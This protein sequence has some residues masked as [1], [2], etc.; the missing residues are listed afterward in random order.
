MFK[1]LSS[2][3]S[4]L[5][6]AA[7]ACLS[8]PSFAEEEQS[9][10]EKN[11]TDASDRTGT[12]PVNFARDIRVYNEY[13]WLNTEGDG[14]QNVTT[15]EYRQSLLDG[16]WQFRTKVP[17]VTSIEADLNDDG[18][19]DIDENGIGDVNFRLL[20][21][22]WFK[23]AHALAPALEVFLDTASEDVLGTGNL[24]LAPQVFYA[25]FFGANPL[26]I[27]GYRGGGLFAPGLQYRFSVHEERG[28][29]ETEA[30]A[31]DI[32][33]LAMS[34]NKTRWLFV[35]PQILLDQENDQEYAFFDIEF[36][37]MMAKWFPELKGHS[38][39][40][41]PSFTIGGD[42]PSDYALEFGYKIVGW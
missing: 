25:Y 41:R 2:A 28:R 20:R 22:P 4:C 37:W 18:R 15:I 27:P 23:G 24:I 29:A 35:N 14:H 6:I 39:Y 13:S 16:Q 3:L 21:K 36:G 5:V 8:V 17:F 40:V 26:P 12:N 38:V 19:D 10:A 7:M 42:R 33:Y 34:E 11:A 32:N 9:Y 30:V 1:S 31:I